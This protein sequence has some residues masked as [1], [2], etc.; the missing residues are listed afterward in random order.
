MHNISQG[1]KKMRKV[2]APVVMAVLIVV[3]S[4]A[5]SGCTAQPEQPELLD[6]QSCQVELEE[7]Y[8]L[9]G[10]KESIT[11]TP[12]F[13][14]ANPNAYEITVE[15]FDYIITADGGV[16]GSGQCTN[17][18]YIPAETTAHLESAFTLLINN[19]IGQFLM[20][21]MSPQDSAAAAMPSW[22]ALGGVLPMAPLQPVWDG[23][24]DGPPV[25][26]VSGSISISRAD[27]KT[28]DIRY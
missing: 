24:P 27:G 22:K 17:P 28:L 20:G 5:L 16:V 3:M 6:L 11:L 21:G 19:V 14:I 4:M 12:I 10:G 7:V 25:Y 8:K 15:T 2:L 1:G 26:K 13:S 9:F 18:I 23:A